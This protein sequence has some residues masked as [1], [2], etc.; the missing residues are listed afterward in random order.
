VLALPALG[1]L[2]WLRA[3]V[4]RLEVVPGTRLDDD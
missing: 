1:L 3:P 4:Q 2:W